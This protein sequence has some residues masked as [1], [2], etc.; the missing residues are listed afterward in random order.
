MKK[1]HA[2]TGVPYLLCL[3]IIPLAVSC[4]QQVRT[5]EESVKPKALSFEGQRDSFLASKSELEAEERWDT[6]KKALDTSSP[7]QIREWL[8]VQKMILTN[9]T[10]IYSHESLQRSAVQE[11]FLLFEHAEPFRQWLEDTKRRG[12]FKDPFVVQN[13]DMVLK[14]LDTRRR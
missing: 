4:S 12:V 14:T 10:A 13:V 3:A 9:S 6:L 1:G 11:F 5:T 2:R 7:V 8:E